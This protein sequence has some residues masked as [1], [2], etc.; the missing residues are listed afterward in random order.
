M[1]KSRCKRDETQISIE[2]RA[3]DNAKSEIAICL[4]ETLFKLLNPTHLKRWTE[5]SSFEENC[6]NK[7]RNENKIKIKH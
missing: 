5:I 1:L 7:K 6:K 2:E 3:A 4:A